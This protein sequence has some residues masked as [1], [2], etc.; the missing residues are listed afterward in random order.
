MCKKAALSSSR[1]VYSS[2]GRELQQHKQKKLKEQPGPAEQAGVDEEEDYEQV[3][4]QKLNEKDATRERAAALPLK[5]DG[6]LVYPD[7]QDTVEPK[8][9]LARPCLRALVI[10]TAHPWHL[11]ALCIRQQCAG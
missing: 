3:P 6:Q 11:P 8:L 9:S 2:G 7:A 1:G 10:T 4:R 5:V